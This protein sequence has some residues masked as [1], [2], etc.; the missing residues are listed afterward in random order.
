LRVKN[1][2][3]LADDYFESQSKS[4]AMTTYDKIVLKGM[5]E[6]IQKGKLEE[7]ARRNEVLVL[8]GLKKS[9]SIMEM[10]DLYDM[11]IEEV[12][13]IVAKIEDEN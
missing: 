5:Q 13:T 10:S 4:L 1:N 2:H 9:L 11:T 8:R 6:G 12:N 3:T 7:Q